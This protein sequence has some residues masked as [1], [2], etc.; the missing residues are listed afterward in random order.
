K[1][2]LKSRALLFYEVFRHNKHH[3]MAKLLLK[4]KMLL[5]IAL[6]MHLTVKIKYDTMKKS[7][8]SFFTIVL[9]AATAHAQQTDTYPVIVSF[10]SMCCGVPSDTPLVKM[11]NTF[12]KQ[13]R[14]KQVSADKIGPMGREGEY[15]LAFRLKEFSKTQKIKFIQQLKKTATTMKDQGNAEVR[16][17]ETVDKAGLGRGTTVSLVKL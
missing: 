15:Y 7:A 2:P 5:T 11:I 1:A 4:S 8:L 13:N 17:N 12:K 6:L 14:I 3:F 16:E 9:L 10:N